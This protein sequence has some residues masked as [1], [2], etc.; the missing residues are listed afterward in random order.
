MTNDQ[1][2][3]FIAVIEAGSF[4]KAAQ[5]LF[6]APQTL[7][8]QIGNLEAELGVKLLD[9]SPQGVR[10]TSGGAEYYRDAKIMLEM[11]DTAKTRARI[12]SSGRPTVRF[13]HCGGRLA[14][15][16]YL[17]DVARAF[18]ERRPDVAQVH[19]FEPDDPE[20]CLSGVETGEFD[21]VE[22]ILD[23]SLRERGMGFTPLA[24][25]KPHLLVSNA[26]PLAGKQQV[27]LSDLDGN[28]IACSSP[29]WFCAIARDLSEQAPSAV[30]ESHPYDSVGIANVCMNMGAF[31]V[32]D[33]V[34]TSNV[35]DLAVVSLPERYDSWFGIAHAASPSPETSA[36]LEVVSEL[37]PRV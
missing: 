10:P 36:V 19:C 1:L 12:A 3:S 17:M 8:Q 22:W 7:M 6:L 11:L 37:F 20:E 24:P 23:P 14:L 9:R 15:K 29:S 4:S 32:W 28:K 31:L 26:H 16:H 35:A 5:K 2:A 13:A 27:E 21:M 30:L 34:D 25:A 33:I 18:S